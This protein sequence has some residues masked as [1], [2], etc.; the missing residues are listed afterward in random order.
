MTL[1][2]YPSGFKEMETYGPYRTIER[3]PA[4]WDPALFFDH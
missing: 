1:I 2:S 4:D 3:K